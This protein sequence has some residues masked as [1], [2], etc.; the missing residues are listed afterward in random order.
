MEQGKQFFCRECNRYYKSHQLTIIE[1]TPFKQTSSPTILKKLKQ[2]LKLKTG[3]RKKVPTINYPGFGGIKI[4]CPAGHLLQFH[5]T[6]I[7]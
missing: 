5:E 1:S 4:F 7:S 2:F 3:N 6:W